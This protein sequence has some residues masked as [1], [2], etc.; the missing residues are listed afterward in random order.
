[1]MGAQLER[2]PQWCCKVKTHVLQLAIMRLYKYATASG[3]YCAVIAF[4]LSLP[5]DNFSGHRRCFLGAFLS[6]SLL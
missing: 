2:K 4:P 5:E 6:Q 3:F 1:M